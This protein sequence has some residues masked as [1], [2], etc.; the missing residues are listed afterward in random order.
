MGVDEGMNADLYNG[1][2]G[3]EARESHRLAR[4]RQKAITKMAKKAAS[5]HAEERDQHYW[6]VFT[7]M[8]AWLLFFVVSVVLCHCKRKSN[9]EAHRN[10]HD[11]D[12]NKAF[13][14]KEQCNDGQM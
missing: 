7:F 4:C 12:G 9:K 14:I 10:K 5:E 13:P 3:K 8:T 1:A 2:E 11:I 6:D